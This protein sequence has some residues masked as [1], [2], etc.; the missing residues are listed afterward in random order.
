MTPCPT[1]GGRVMLVDDYEDGRGV[2]SEM[3]CIACARYPFRVIPT[4]TLQQMKFENTKGRR[5]LPTRGG[6]TL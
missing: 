2:V 5:R 4:A 3:Q 1:C 6:L